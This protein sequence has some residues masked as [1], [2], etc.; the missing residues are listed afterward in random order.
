M[1]KINRK[2]INAVERCE[3]YKGIKLSDWV[4]TPSYKPFN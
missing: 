1:Q 2:Q 3:I 4:K